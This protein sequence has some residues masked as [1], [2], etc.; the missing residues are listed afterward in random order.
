ML[1][2]QRYN[3]RMNRVTCAHHLCSGP[4][5]RMRARG[6]VPSNEGRRDCPH[7]V[8]IVPHILA[9]VPYLGALLYDRTFSFFINKEIDSTH[10]GQGHARL[11][12]DCAGYEDVRERIIARAPG[13]SRSGRVEVLERKLKV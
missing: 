13:W 4:N 7:R 11:G 2:S 10:D 9:A 6:D 3:Y 8:C 12:R 5:S 1:N